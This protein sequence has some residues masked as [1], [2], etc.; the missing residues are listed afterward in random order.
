MAIERFGDYTFPTDALEEDAKLLDGRSALQ[1]VPG[2]D[3]AFDMLGDECPKAAGTVTHRFMLTSTTYEGLDT[4]EDTFRAAMRQ[5]R[6]KLYWRMRDGSQRWAWAKAIAVSMP[7]GKTTRL[8]K[9]VVVTFEVAEGFRYDRYSAA[10][11]LWGDFEWGDDVHWGGAVTTSFAFSGVSTDITV[12][13]E[14]NAEALAEITISC[15][16]IQSAENV[17]VS[18]RVGGADVEWFQATRVIAASK[19]LVVDCAAYSVEYDGADDYANF[20]IGTNQ[21]VWLTLQPGDNTIRIVCANGGDAGTIAW[22]FYPTF[23]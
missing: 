16:A 12:T 10:G 13:N 9:P 4:A 3:G 8:I 19:A 6:Q 17:K 23:E 14:G 22:D 5:G 7:A 21:V 2:A 20:S 18:R 11:P 15:S 1:A